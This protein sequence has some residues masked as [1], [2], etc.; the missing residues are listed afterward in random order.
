MQEHQ[1]FQQDCLDLLRGETEGRTVDRRGFLSALAILG[2]SPA[3]FR[4]TPAR[5]QTKEIVVVNGR[6]SGSLRGPDVRVRE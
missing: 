3:L 6:T 2:I 5:A 4:L 1:T